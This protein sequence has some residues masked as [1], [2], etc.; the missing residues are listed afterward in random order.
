MADQQGAESQVE[1]LKTLLDV[2]RQLAVTIELPALLASVERAA[3]QV[4]RCERASV[5][6]YD[7]KAQ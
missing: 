6:I 1:D 4:L 5:F 7:V 2:T 3:R